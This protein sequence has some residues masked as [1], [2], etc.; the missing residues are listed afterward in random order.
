M[1]RSCLGYLLHGMRD[2]ERE[3]DRPTGAFGQARQ[4][5]EDSCIHN[6][7][8]AKSAVLQNHPTI[9]YFMLASSAVKELVLL[10]RRPSNQRC[11]VRRGLSNRAAPRPSPPRGRRFGPGSVW[12]K[13]FA[14]ISTSRYYADVL[15]S[16]V[17][18]PLRQ[19]Q[20]RGEGGGIKNTANG[21][22]KGRSR[23][24]RSPREAA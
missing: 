21:A 9:S 3:R 7:R 17:A 23:P 18:W 20:I 11:F 24:Y 4:A 14:V 8:E 19:R 16:V 10:T 12:R 1:L 22:G 2:R 6:Q 13:L 5:S 15:L